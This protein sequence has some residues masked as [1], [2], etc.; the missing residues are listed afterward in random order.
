[1]ANLI[2][3]KRSAT[4]GNN[5]TTANLQLGELAI[6]TYDG[7]LFFKK[8]VSGTESILSV[9]TLTG[10]QT[11][12][13]KSLISPIVLGYTSAAAGV[14]QTFTVTVVN[15]G[16]GNV[17]A[18]DGVSTPTLSFVRTGVYT[19]T[20]SDAS[21]SGH[22]IAFKDGSGTSYTTGV[23]TTGTPGSAGAQTV[24]TVASD[25]PA[26]LR[27]YCV[28]HGNGMG[29]TIAVTGTAGSQVSGEIQLNCHV[30]THGQKIAAQ[31]HSQAATN[32]LTLPGGTTIGNADAVLV[33]DTG[34]QT[35]TNKTISGSSNTLS[36][37]GNASLTNSSVT[38][39]GSSISLG[40]SATIT[41]NTTNALTIGTGLSGSS[42]NGSSAVTIAL[43]SA[44][45]D[46]L[47][48]YASK[49]ANFILA[50]PNGSAGV[51]V[52]RAV[53][54][55]DIPTLNQNTTG[56]AGSVTN[57]LTIGTGL[58]GS[59]FNGS[60][61]VTIALANTAVTAGSY[62]NA[63]ITVDAQG[64]ITLASN[65][66]GGGGAGTVTSITAGTGLTGGTITSSGTIA[67]DSTVVT[68][69]GTQTLTNKTLTSPIIGT[70]SNTGTLT[71]PTST[72]T[73]VGR[74]TTD[75][76]TNKTL[77]SAVFTGTITAGGGVGES[78]QVLTST[79][80]GVTWTTPSGGAGGAGNSFSTIAVSGQSSVLADSS[81]DTLTLDTG[82][83]IGII[84]NAST[85]TITFTT[86][87]SFPFTKYDGSASNIPL[88]T[89]AS[90][91]ASS[92]DTV[93][94]P[95]IK[96]DGTSVTTLKLTA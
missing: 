56:S 71:L 75:T 44:Y 47:N 77:S 69:T 92:L 39:N 2:T 61:A 9:A 78:G 84:T 90:A 76:L 74:A 13:N 19:F 54:A 30:N 87:K 59:S 45:G 34:T 21:N 43:A 20:Q 11:L 24:I 1:M 79:V 64:R 4:S 67:I 26:D 89:E 37:I 5:P 28:A 73:L 48:P 6:N 16:Y 17:F 36:N 88:F 22:Q 81:A 25:A 93:F 66:S 68:L 65:G 7:N 49:T 52:F 62:T 38:V 12:S 27:Y 3:L 91:L 18:V 55:A 50:A 23:V 41:A 58:S 51:P 95:F 57:A 14:S 31:P 33:S 80:S 46:T 35:L 60:S 96:T 82:G 29:N 72:D 40:G 63:N 15:S 86:N 94:L 32:K 85:D 53:V 83:L 42:F 8:S 70:I 10:T